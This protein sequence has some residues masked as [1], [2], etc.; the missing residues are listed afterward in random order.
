M[1]NSPI[2]RTGQSRAPRPVVVLLGSI[3]A[4]LGCEPMARTEIPIDCA[5][6]ERNIERDTN[7]PDY[8]PF[9]L[10]P[11]S[12]VPPDDN[13]KNNNEFFCF[14][15]ES[16]DGYPANA[17]V[18]PGGGCQIPQVELIDGGNAFCAGQDPGKVAGTYY[19]RH[20]SAFV[21]RAGG[22]E[23][24]GGEIANWDWNQGIF[25]PFIADGIGF[26]ARSD[27]E[28]DKFITV[29]LNDYQSGAPSDTVPGTTYSPFLA[30][31]G[32]EAGCTPTA[33]SASNQIGTSVVAASTDPNVQTSTSSLTLV[34]TPGQCGNRWR[35]LLQTSENWE[36]H[37]LS[38]DSFYQDRQPNSATGPL[39]PSVLYSLSFGISR[40]MTV[41][42]W[43]DEIFLYR[44]RPSTTDH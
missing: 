44:K 36:L 20:R 30:T 4:T 33:G 21:I 23:F 35:T 18:F 6:A 34:N 42:L 29:Y 12:G 8:F 19:P 13:S 40:D 1:R 39:D 9:E 15:D 22:H 26:W 27:V 16:A 11:A 25:P 43:I 31:K 28:S 41:S 10:D 32:L 17:S 5:R 38:F 24:Y 14:A 7:T 3:A 2:C 37:L